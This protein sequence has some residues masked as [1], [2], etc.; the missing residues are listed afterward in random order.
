MPG[1][2]GASSYVVDA[3][4]RSLGDASPF[5][6]KGILAIKK[7]LRKRNTLLDKRNWLIRYLHNWKGSTFNEATQRYLI[8]VPQGAT[9]ADR[10]HIVVH[11]AIFD[12]VYLGGGKDY[13]SIMGLR[14]DAASKQ[15]VEAKAASKQAK[16]ASMQKQEVDCWSQLVEQGWRRICLN[17]DH[18][19]YMYYSP[20]GEVFFRM[21]DAQAHHSARPGSSEKASQ[22]KTNGKRK[23][24]EAIATLAEEGDDDRKTP[25]KGD[26]LEFEIAEPSARCGVEWLPGVVMS[27]NKRQ[28]TFQARIQDGQ[29]DENSWLETYRFSEEGKEWR[30]LQAQRRG[31]KYDKQANSNAWIKQGWQTTK[32]GLSVGTSESAGSSSQCEQQCTHKFSKQDVGK[33]IRI[34]CEDDGMMSVVL[35]KHCRHE[36]FR[37]RFLSD[38]NEMSVDLSQVDYEMLTIETDR[39]AKGIVAPDDKVF[40]R[41]A[42][43][44]AG[45]V[46]RASAFA[47]ASKHKDVS[48]RSRTRV[49]PSSDE[50][51]PV[52]DAAQFSTPAHHQTKQT[53]ADAAFTS[54]SMGPIRVGDHVLGRYRDNKWYDAVV[55]AVVCSSS[56][57]GTRYALKWRDGDLSDTVKTREEIAL[58]ERDA[59]RRDLANRKQADGDEGAS[60]AAKLPSV[61]SQKAGGQ[62]T[63]A[64][65]APLGG[66]ESLATPLRTPEA[67]VCDACGQAHKKCAHRQMAAEAA[68]LS[69]PEQKEKSKS[70]EWKHWRGDRAG[71]CGSGE[72]GLD[73]RQRKA[74]TGCAAWVV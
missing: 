1:K 26:T 29:D 65:R 33:T 20:D 34:N 59:R 36:V 37:V 57:R 31:S 10:K 13:P 64:A 63:E 68:R 46:S 49:Q 38:Q 6:S 39:R 9:D 55:E 15:V 35:L 58:S 42:D 11:N 2:K 69:P 41:C 30:W 73:C 27:I 23:H 71:A 43:A 17:P 4:A 56:I 21:S 72:A 22:Y 3:A 54:C 62:G 70:V 28:Q 61:G 50:S 18:R 51:S 5:L 45:H 60:P 66:I 24:D 16:A 67:R 14:Y 44:Q 12:D 52:F 25:K 19:K 47:N 32:A 48:L 8:P 53:D 74:Q 7:Q 40:V